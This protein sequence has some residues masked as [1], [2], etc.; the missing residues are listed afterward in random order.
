VARYWLANCE[1][2]AVR[3]GAHGVVERLLRD[4]NPHLTT[5]L[6]VRT[7][8]RRRS[9]VSVD[10]VAAVDPARRVI[11][12]ERVPR[13]PARRAGPALR[14]SIAAAG[15]PLRHVLAVVQ[16]AVLRAVEAATPPTRRALAVAGEVLFASLLALAAEAEATARAATRRA[17]PR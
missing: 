14:R 5:R 9:V 1:G 6:V 10:A 17:R 16:S 2:F 4:A 11:T 12:V 13:V 15:P 8:S 7:W 3:G